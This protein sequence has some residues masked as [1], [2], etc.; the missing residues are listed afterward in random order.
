MTRF[1]SILA[2]AVAGLFGQASAA[3]PKYPVSSIPEALRKD[4]NV[5]IRESDVKFTI[6]ARDRSFFYKRVVVTILNAKGNDYASHVVFYDKDSRI[7]DI[8]AMVYD[9]SGKQIKRLR[10]KDI[11]DQSAFDG[12]SLFSDNRLR[13]VD[14]TQATYPY[15]VEFEYEVE[16][17]L[18]FAIPT[19][20]V[21]SEEEV[22]VQRSSYTLAFAAG[23]EPRFKA[24][25]TDIEPERGTNEEGH[26][27]VRWTF[28]NVKPIKFEPSSD[29][30]E[31][32]TTIAAA[33][34]DFQ[35]GE[36]SGNMSTWENFGKWFGKLNEG[37]NDLSDATRQ[38]VRELT[39]GLP[40]VE[41][42]VKTL[43]EY[44]QGKTRY[45]S[46]KLGIGGLQ[47]FPAS[48]VDKNGYGDCKAL[49]NYMISMLETVGIKG[50]YTLID[51]GWD[52]R[53][54]DESF[55]RSQFNHAI[56]MVPTENDTIWLEC[57]SQT[58]PFGYQGGFTGDRKALIITD[59][60]ARVVT[61]THYSAEDNLRLRRGDVY[62]QASGDARTVVTTA[63]SGIRYD[64]GGLSLTL[65]NNFDHQKKWIQSTTNIPSFDIAGFSMK[66]H[67]GRVPTAEVN[68]E[69]SLRR[70][71][72]VSGK[73]FFLAPNLMSRVDYIPEKVEN[74]KTS[75]VRRYAYTDIDTIRY[76][77]PEEIYP[78]FLP[79]PVKIQSRFGEYE[80]SFIVDQGNL[81]Y[82]RKMKMFRGKFPPET[83]PELIEFFKGVSKADNV[84]MVF[85]SKT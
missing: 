68:L 1:Y 49:S 25:N 10:N 51:A 28:E 84:K 73:R 82:T 31:V 71:A 65:N 7:K 85:L 35:Y 43:Y 58:N 13:A 54:L 69:L 19:F 27:F 74:R 59:D 70:F 16:F 24:K 15:T 32:L 72:T 55:P 78:E 44:L 6:H 77:L 61:T 23:L 21:I 20:T 5:V 52:A 83:Y 40:T 17:K 66:D 34:T 80:T 26:Q 60:G 47:P 18:L 14:L 8:N 30:N 45:V 67:K 9:A 46:I 36:H 11:Y 63:Y 62:V 4:V 39:D 22:S 29:R 38:K 56:V 64:D 76:H 57:T 48:V 41:E 50:Y 2:I 3:D 81:I 75:V 79:E 42:K 12:Y 53:P 37:R 33:P